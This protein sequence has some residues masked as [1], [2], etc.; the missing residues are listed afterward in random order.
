MY[1]TDEYLSLRF[2]INWVFV[3]RYIGP[4][5]IKQ[6]NNVKWPNSKF[7]AEREHTPA[8]FLFSAWTVAPS[9]QIQL[10]DCSATLDRL[11]ELKLSRT[12]LN[13]LEVI[14]KV[15][16][17][18]TLPSW[19]LKFPIV[20]TW[21]ELQFTANFVSWKQLMLSWFEKDDKLVSWARSISETF[22]STFRS[23]WV[24]S[25]YFI[26][27]LSL[28]ILAS[29]ILFNILLYNDMYVC[30]S[31][32]LFVLCVSIQHVWLH[33]TKIC[34]WKLN[35]PSFKERKFARR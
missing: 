14:F 15:M 17:S 21:H 8:N 23:R 26:E 34:F 20:L 10:P 1:F 19:L 33:W 4:L 2:G 12:S 16:F 9:S 6:N 27:C 31:V 35:D 30:L 22:H 24:A 5:I 11:N 29:E 25:I 32:C 3:S 18:L 13:Y 7:Y 28:L